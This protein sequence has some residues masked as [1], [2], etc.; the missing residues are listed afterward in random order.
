MKGIESCW[1][2]GRARHLQRAHASPIWKGSSLLASVA[3]LTECLSWFSSILTSVRLTFSLPSFVLLGPGIW[4]CW[5]NRG[6]WPWSAPQ[7]PLPGHPH[8]W[9]LPSHPRWAPSHSWSLIS[10]PHFPCCPGLLSTFWSLASPLLAGLCHPAMALAWAVT[11]CCLLVPAWGTISEG[12]SEAGA[13]EG[14]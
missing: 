2:A 8:C 12:D 11:L 4:P 6:R 13:G 3:E 10:H 1:P 5:P 14:D 7:L 9:A